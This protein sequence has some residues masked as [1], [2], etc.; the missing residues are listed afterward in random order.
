MSFTVREDPQP[1]RIDVD[2]TVW[3]YRPYRKTGGRHHLH[4]T[5][6]Y[7]MNRDNAYTWANRG[8]AETFA[9][10]FGGVVEEI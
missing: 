6:M 9:N 10:R 2:R 5:P 7:T 4:V 1:H 3:V 8:P